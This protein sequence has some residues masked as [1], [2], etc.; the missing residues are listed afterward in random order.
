[1]IFLALIVV[2]FSLFI[3]FSA[4]ILMSD[5]E[6]KIFMILTNRHWIEVIPKYISKC[7]MPIS[8]LCNNVFKL[9]SPFDGNLGRDKKKYGK[10]IW[11]SSD[12]W[13]CSGAR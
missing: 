7:I 4:L 12:I 6:E 2:V 13:H 8:P 5:H 1:M 9:I 3:P 11:H 10:T